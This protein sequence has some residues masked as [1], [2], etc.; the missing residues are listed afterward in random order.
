[1]NFTKTK[2]KCPGQLR[3]AGSECIDEYLAF[4][5]YEAL[6]KVV[7]T[8]TQDQVIQE[9]LIPDCAEEAAPDSRQNE[10]EICKSGAK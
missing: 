9:I 10:M 4:K 5:G 6:Y 3:T 1:M 7:T 2:P 8:M